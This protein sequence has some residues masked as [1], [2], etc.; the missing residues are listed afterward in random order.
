M[1]RVLRFPSGLA[2]VYRDDGSAFCI[3]FDLNSKV[4][5]VP[6]VSTHQRGAAAPAACYA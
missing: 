3:M 6:D 4:G 1:R 2:A 5:D